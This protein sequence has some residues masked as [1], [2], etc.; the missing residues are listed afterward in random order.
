MMNLLHLLSN[1][2]ANLFE[3]LLQH[4]DIQAEDS[5]YVLFAKDPQGKYIAGSNP[6]TRIA[7]LNHPDHIV[8]LHDRELS[9]APEASETIKHDQIILQREV[10][11]VFTEYGTGHDGYIH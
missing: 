10:P 2:T 9:W 6:Y 8:G 1:G 3:N 11:R 4:E 7:G 5:Q